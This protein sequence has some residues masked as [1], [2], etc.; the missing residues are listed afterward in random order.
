MQLSKLP[1]AS[2]LYVKA[3]HLLRDY[4]TCQCKDHLQSLSVQSK[5]EG[6]VISENSFKTWKRLYSSFHPGQLSFLLQAASDT[7]PTAI[8]LW[9][10]SAQCDAKSL[11]CDSTTAYIL[12]GFP[13]ALNQ[14]HYTFQHNQVLSISASALTNLIFDAPFVKV[15]IYADCD[16]PNS[17]AYNAPQATIPSN[18]LITPYH[19]DIVTFNTKCPSICLLELTCPLNSPQHIQAARD[20]K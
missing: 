16:L 7:L 15:Y 20:R 17:Y 4:I 13:T 2:S 6:S 10:W 12:G 3:K 9:R 11:L 14:Q 1:S 8:N 5:F 18:I 19:P